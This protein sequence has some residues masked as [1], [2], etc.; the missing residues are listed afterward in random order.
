MSVRDRIRDAQHLFNAGQ[1]DGALLSLLVATAAAARRRYPWGTMSLR[2]P[3]KQMQDRECFTQFLSDEMRTLSANPMFRTERL[4]LH[5]AG[6]E[7]QLQEILYD[8]FRSTLVH[9]ARTS[10]K[11]EILPG[12]QFQLDFTQPDRLRTSCW[13][14]R[15]LFHVLAS[16]PETRQELHLL[17]VFQYELVECMGYKWL[18]WESWRTGKL[19]SE[20]GMPVFRPAFDWK[21]E[22]AKFASDPEI[23][24]EPRVNKPSRGVEAPVP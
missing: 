23:K 5:V 17:D 16:V 2:D 12:T 7:A 21:A 8:Y 13:I 1:F 10:P 3:K 22:Y 6:E 15:G 19:E 14:H 20:L 24:L 11:V 18:A 4:R 9:E